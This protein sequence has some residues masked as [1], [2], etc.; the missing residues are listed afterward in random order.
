MDAMNWRSTMGKFA[1][2]V[3]VITTVDE[4][5]NPLGM[6]AN[7]F[8]SLSLDPPMVLICVDNKSDT[9]TKLLASNKYGVNILADHQEPLS[10]AFA[11]KGGSE[12]FEGIAYSTGETGVPV[13]SGCLVSVECIVKE[14]V[15]GG[16]HMILL[17]EGVRIHEEASVTEPLLFYRGKYEKLNGIGA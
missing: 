1:T 3:T 11:R 6:T 14:A 8:T 9:L 16:D 4:A 5:G 17:G 7:A 12:K 15:Q 2:G 10:R 13:L